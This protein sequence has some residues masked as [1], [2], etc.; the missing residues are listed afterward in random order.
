MVS[1]EWVLPSLTSIST[2]KKNHKLSNSLAQTQQDFLCVAKISSKIKTASSFLKPFPYGYMDG[3]IDRKRL[4]CKHSHYFYFLGSC[5][6]TQPPFGFFHQICLPFIK[7]FSWSF[8]SPLVTTQ[9]YKYEKT[10]VVVLVFYSVV[11][12]NHNVS[13]VWGLV[14]NVLFYILLP[15]KTHFC[16]FIRGYSRNKGDSDKVSHSQANSR[17]S[18]YNACII[19]TVCVFVMLADYHQWVDRYIYKKIW[20]VRKMHVF[21]RLLWYYT[22]VFIV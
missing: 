8:F 7:L 10:V 3:K 1:I 17:S 4:S 5:T 6:H 2:T 22:L 18:Q 14:G 20:H 9:L 15:H 16:R 11:L 21:G 13:C 12:S 19:V